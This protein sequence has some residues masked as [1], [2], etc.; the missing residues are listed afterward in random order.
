MSTRTYPVVAA[1][2]YPERLPLAELE[3][4]TCGRTSAPLERP[5]CRMFAPTGRARGERMLN[6]P[7]RGTGVL[8][9]ALRK[10]A[11]PATWVLNFYRSNIGK[12][13]VM[14]V[15]GIILLGFVLIHMIGNLKLYAGEE[16][17]NAYGEWIREFLYPA[18]PHE[19][20]LWI[21]RGVLLVSVLL[22]IHAATSLTLTN[23]KA[24]PVK[25]QGGRNYAVA[26]YAARTMRWSGIIIFFFII[27]HLLDF[28]QGAANPDFIE[29]EP[30]HNVI[31]SF[32]QWP[33]AGF[34]IVANVLLGVHIYH[35][36]WS[37]FQSLGLNNPRFNRWRR[38]F[39]I[40]FAAAIVIGNVSFPIAVLAGVID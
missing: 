22:H 30:Y 5:G 13:W 19:G 27:Y 35:G 1:F 9:P 40:A 14:A 38:Y 21:M 7:V 18:L 15:T 26:D 16:D 24:R 33:V 2:P 4:P 39:A 36:A 25:Y 31:Q 32:E 23:R 37:M 28:T 8:V 12:K 17:M 6:Q 34:Y 3:T 20:F 11:V 29:G 10:G